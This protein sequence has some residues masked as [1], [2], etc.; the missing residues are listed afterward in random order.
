MAEI[1][2]PQQQEAVRNRG[3]KLLV[4]AAAGSGKTKVLVDRLLSYIMDTFNPANID[5]FLIIT[6]TK[7]AAAELRGKIASKLSERI[8][9][10]PE[11]RHL[12]QQLQRLYL[13]KISTV[14][15]FCADIVREYA[16]KL[17]TAVDFRVADENECAEI[18]QR[19]MDLILERSYSEIDSN[20]DFQAFVDSQGLGRDDR[21]VPQI[22]Q[23]V[24]SKAIC[25]LNPDEWLNWCLDVSNSS[26]FRDAGETIWGRFL[27]E[28]LHICLDRLILALTRCAQA[29]QNEQFMEKPA[30][31][32][33]E[34]VEQ[35]RLLR[36]C[37]T[38]DQI[39]E[40]NS[41]S[42]GTLTFSKKCTDADLMRRIKSV[43]AFCK[44][45]LTKKLKRFAGNSHQILDDLRQS[46]NAVKGLIDMV[47]AYGEA[48][49][50]LKKSRRVLDFSD[51]EQKALD[52]LVGKNRNTVT[53][54][55][56]E[57]G[58][59]YREIMVDEYQDSNEVQDAIFA[60]LTSRS[61]G[62]FMV[63][64][65]KQSIYQ[66]RLADPGIFLEKYNS[67][68][69]AE[70]AV[71]FRGRKV[72]LSQ[73][74]RSSAGVIDA[75]N[76]VFS[77][78]M[79]TRVGGLD[80]GDDEK[81]YE[82]VPH[83]ALPDNEV[84]L[85]GIAVQSDTYGEEAA[86]VAGRIRQMIDEGC[87]IREK[88]KLRTVT[89]GDIVILLRSPGS[90]GGVFSDALAKC[91]IRSDTGS[92]MDLLMAEEIETLRSILQIISNPQQD[93]PLLGAMMS[94][95][96]SFTAEEI[97]AARCNRP[98]GSVFDAVKASDEPRFRQFVS[99]LDTLRNAARLSTLTQLIDTVLTET[100]LDSIFAAMPDGDIRIE[101][102][103][104]FCNLALQ[105]EKRGRGDLL[106]F[107][108]YLT[109]MDERGLTVQTDNSGA[110]TVKIMSIH[111]SKG[112]EFP[113]VFLCGTSKSF[114]MEDSRQQVLCDSTL[115]I[116]M[117]FV[118]AK[119]RIRYPSIAKR[120][121]AAKMQ[122]DTISEE[123]RV[124]YVA[125]TRAKDRLIMTYAS[126]YITNELE[127]ICSRIDMVD[128][129]LLA[130]EA[131]C[132]GDWIL[133]TAVQRT[134]AVAFSKATVPPACVKESSIPWTI[135]FIEQVQI[136]QQGAFV[137]CCCENAIPEETVCRIENSLRFCY[138]H[139]LATQTPSKLTATQLKGRYKDQEAS[140]GTPH[141]SYGTSWRKPSFAAKE[142]PGKVYGT[143][144][145]AVMHYIDYGACETPDSVQQ[146]LLRLKESGFI[147][148]EQF[149]SVNAQDIADFFSTDI[150]KRVR[151]GDKVLREFKFSVLEDAGVYVDG[152]DGEYILLQGV[153][154]C[155]IVESD[156]ITII[157]FKTDNVTESNLPCKIDAYRMQVSTYARAMERIY[158]LP[159][160]ETILYFFKLKRAVSL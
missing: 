60:A 92:S 38:W 16:Y 100:R 123:L 7:A 53:S 112:L 132:C 42:Y 113:V 134:D 28:D 149:E 150:G 49:S 36:S 85:Y 61:H 97:S 91:G 104:S 33:W 155:A 41:I 52:L 27:I 67:Y 14:H 56:S 78:C 29:A 9:Q 118:D 4:S 11:N 125:M 151:K 89:P 40:N 143:T 1:L 121:I 45:V 80:Y 62:C 66:F 156:G 20:P 48:Y 73:N 117:C 145:H 147:S 159:V 130:E 144:L 69:P 64:D 126:K 111:K 39:I 24:Y 74:F 106:S 127:D 31:L 160:K 72:L 154:D 35:L 94:R 90:V 63:G 102:I 137:E 95:V 122:A 3:G 131:N 128:P 26:S 98:F 136:Q 103:Q 32:L 124:L 23:N 47:R 99:S 84:A 37:D 18:Q 51:L 13:T 25:H 75:V 110:D 105:F 93:I 22:I 68:L 140:E 81:L 119:N 46:Q 58:A 139:R 30:Q 17:D 82:G 86:F 115:G 43:R 5:D 65:V 12:Q 148:L 59:R 87:L 21:A 135:D 107:L 19:A 109:V 55:A 79:S 96:Y 71:E 2:T 142:E 76:D 50:S 153:V 54:V 57:I 116:G 157:D 158:S 120:A 6:Y 83:V 129:T 152:A 108:D 114:N 141:A 15:S 44:E 77:G 8:A 88:D 70:K 10:D 133:Q 34:T 101:N 138:P 146:E